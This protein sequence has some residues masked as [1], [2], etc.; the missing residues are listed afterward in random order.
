MIAMCEGTAKFVECAADVG[1]RLAPDALERAITARSKWLFLNS[2]NNPSGAVYTRADLRALADVLSRHPQV[3]IISDD[4]YEHITYDDGAF[5]TLAEVEPRLYERT[6]TVNGMSKGYCM[7]GWRV[8]FAGGPKPLIEAINMVQ[9]QSSTHTST[10]SQWA[11]IAALDGPCDF[12]D[13]NRRVFE[14]RRDLVVSML[15]QAKGLSCA[16]PSGAYYAYPSCAGVIGKRTPAQQ[17]ITSDE[18]FVDYLLEAE[19]VAAVA[20]TVFG[21]APHFRISYATATSALE[22]A[23]RRIQRACGALG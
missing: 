11:A 1:F 23:C 17:T 14:Q 2:P 18:D 16:K 7:T 15:N 13:R 19:G 20:G 5:A 22:E 4:I 12:I 3:S 6:L 9:S 10:I 8:G 21:L